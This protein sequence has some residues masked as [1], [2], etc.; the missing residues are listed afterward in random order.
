MMQTCGFTDSE[1]EADGGCHDELVSGS[2][3]VIVSTRWTMTVLVW[4][5]Q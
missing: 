2:V 1:E 5:L 3:V 4:Y